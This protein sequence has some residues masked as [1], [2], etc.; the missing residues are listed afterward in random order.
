MKRE[1]KGKYEE[2]VSARQQ[3]AMTAED[4]ENE[5]RK[6]WKELG[7]IRKKKTRRRKMDWFT[8][9][10]AAMSEERKQNKEAGKMKQANKQRM[11]GWKK[12]RTKKKKRNEWRKA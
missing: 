3:M 4:K 10:I 7:W 6:K 5:L 1:R 11:D 8:I 12:W 2:E 9:I